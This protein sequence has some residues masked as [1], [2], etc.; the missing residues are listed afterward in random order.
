MKVPEHK[1]FF[2]DTEEVKRL[3]DNMQLDFIG[4]IHQV[5][6]FENLWKGKRDVIIKDESG[7]IKFT[8]WEENARTFPGKPGS[9]IVIKNGQ[10]RNVAGVAP[11]TTVEVTSMRVTKQ[12]SK[13]LLTITHLS[14]DL[15]VQINPKRCPIVKERYQDLKSWNSN[16]Q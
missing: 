6:P 15:L 11:I 14:F 1:Y 7:Q 4:I 10:R 3:N 9:V 12:S 13:G 5:G 8:I 16:E 2:K